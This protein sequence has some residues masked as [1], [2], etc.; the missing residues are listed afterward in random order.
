M[1]TRKLRRVSALLAV[2]MML[3]LLPT[4]AFAEDGNNKCGENLTWELSEDGTLTISGEGKM[5]NYGYDRKLNTT[6]TPWELERPLITKVVIKGGVTSIGD[7]AF[8]GCANLESVD[9]S[10][11]SSLTTIGTS[12]YDCKK[13][14]GVKLYEG[15]VTIGGSA[16]NHCENLKSIHIPST[17]MAIGGWCFE[18][19]TSLSE[20]TFEADSQLTK[21]AKKNVFKLW[22]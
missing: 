8:S 11:A 5:E 19:C 13:L 21:I 7:N 12:F 1:K 9:L 14:D 4:A 15:L 2:A 6:T 10:R 3:A 17:V 18:S 22:P 16:F 20:V